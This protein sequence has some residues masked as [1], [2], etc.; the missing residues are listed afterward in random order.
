MRAKRLRKAQG[1]WGHVSRRPGTLP[2]SG[3]LLLMTTWGGHTSFVEGQGR[4]L[5]SNVPPRYQG[6][7]GPPGCQLR[8][9]SRLSFGCQKVWGFGLFSRCVVVG[10][11]G[12]GG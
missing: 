9:V 1:L 10:R 11:A 8:V 5:F 4:S 7:V 3:L 2:D 12:L 6:C